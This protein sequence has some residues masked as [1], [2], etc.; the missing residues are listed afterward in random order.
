VIKAPLRPPAHESD[1]P[2]V[3]QQE[4]QGRDLLQVEDVLDDVREAALIPR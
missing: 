1:D 2:G 3:R 4:T